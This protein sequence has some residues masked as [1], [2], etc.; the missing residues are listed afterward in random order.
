MDSITIVNILMK[1]H[2]KQNN[3]MLLTKNSFTQ[4]NV[5]KILLFKGFA[6]VICS[7]S[8]DSFAHPFIFI[9]NNH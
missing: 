3:E 1:K 5:G 8:F 2:Y 6:S 4:Q 9:K 7:K